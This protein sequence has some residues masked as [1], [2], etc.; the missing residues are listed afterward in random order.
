[1]MIIVP[2]AGRGKRF[3]KAGYKMPKPLIDVCGK[4]MIERV[5]ECLPYSNYVFIAL[6][7]Q[8]DKGLRKSL[9]GQIVEINKVTEGAACTVL[10]AEHLIT[11]YE[12][13]IINCD[14]ILNFN[15]DEFIKYARKFD[16]CIITFKSTDP[17]HSYSRVVKG[18]VV[19]VA[20]K[21]VISNNKK[22]G[23]DYMIHASSLLRN[24]RRYPLQIN[25]HV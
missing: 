16:G 3:I 2:M 8:L 13:I 23:L 19:E 15:F 5:L 18:K 9:K 25:H 10:L 21:K 24:I 17:S 1:M 6:K 11:D 7:E 20:E 22:I 12:L 14:Q 4:P